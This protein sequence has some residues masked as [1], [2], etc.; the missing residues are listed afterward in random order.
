MCIAELNVS[1]LPCRH[2][3]YHLSRS[4]SPSANLSN[5]GSRLGI[6]GW[7]IKCDFCPYCSGWNLSNSEY[8]LVGND[9]APASGGLS[10]SPSLTLNTTRRELRR[11]SLSRTDSNS[12]IATSITMI[13]AQ[14]KNRA[15]NAR[16]NEYFRVPVSEPTP[17]PSA[18]PGTLREIDEEDGNVATSPSDTSS[19]APDS[20]RHSSTSSQPESASILKK[21]RRKS[22]RLSLSIFK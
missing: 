21:M 22:K 5:C 19:D 10:R 17:I 18:Y 2:R 20:V 16:V 7:E 14:E 12:S 8:R 3:W 9:R 11:G 4:C 13:Q 1:V 6:S 15:L